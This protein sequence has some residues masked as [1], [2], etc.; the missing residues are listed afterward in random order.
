MTMDLLPSGRY[1][2]HRVR[3]SGQAN[4]LQVRWS[5]R[6]VREHSKQGRGVQITVT[7]LHG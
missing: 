7:G 3:P 5:P 1:V 4:R 6:M 2:P